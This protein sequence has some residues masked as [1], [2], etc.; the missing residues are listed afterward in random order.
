MLVWG[1]EELG[2]PPHLAPAAFCLGP[3]PH[4]CCP[5]H[6]W[7]PFLSPLV[8]HPP[9][10]YL[11]PSPPPKPPQGVRRAGGGVCFDA[12]G[13]GVGSEQAGQ[14]RLGWGSGA[15]RVVGSLGAWSLPPGRQLLPPPLPSQEGWGARVPGSPQ[16]RCCPWWRVLHWSEWQ[17]GDHVRPR[18]VLTGETFR[19]TQ[20]GLAEA[21]PV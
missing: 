3:L 20:S 19:Q 12:S 8:P 7:P 6:P 10:C 21:F 15:R 1:A 16:R 17:L 4:F 9:L 2:R 5:D 11:T 13:A 14:D 18:E